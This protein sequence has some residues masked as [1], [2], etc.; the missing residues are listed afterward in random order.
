MRVVMSATAAPAV[1]LVVPIA[2]P[3]PPAGGTPIAAPPAPATPAPAVTIDWW[4]RLNPNER[5]II[6]NW[7]TQERRCI[8]CNRTYLEI[9]N[10]GQWK[11][12][13]SV[14]ALVD[15]KESSA[16]QTMK[17]LVRADHRWAYNPIHWTESDNQIL[18][19]DMM[20]YLKVHGFLHHQSIVS[21]NS[22]ETHGICRFDWRAKRSFDDAFLYYTCPLQ[23]YKHYHPY[24][25][26]VGSISQRLTL[27][28]LTSHDALYSKDS[29]DS[30]IVRTPHGEAA[31]TIA[32]V[33]DSSE[34][35]DRRWRMEIAA[36]RMARRRVR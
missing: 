22:T 2:V 24:D 3:I 34:A 27:P 8:F 25:L 20:N 18:S 29:D 32:S 28:Y 19:T 14:S 21:T 16:F 12:A 36:S 26:R 23:S 9:D 31:R 6:N 30:R 33:Q 15:I 5:K 1:P 7:Q 13:Q 17:Q 11:C 4:A 35:V 10:L